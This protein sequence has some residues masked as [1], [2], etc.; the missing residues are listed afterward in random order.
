MKLGEKEPVRFWL[1]RQIQELFFTFLNI[2]VF[3]LLF[4][5]I[6]SFSMDLDE[7]NMA[8]L[9]DWWALVE[10]WAVLRA[11][12]GLIVLLIPFINTEIRSPLGLDFLNQF[13][14][15]YDCTV[16]TSGLFH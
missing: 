11:I 13:I 12:L 10:V 8:Y 4:F 5:D 7:N 16:K 14:W 1:R 15:M 6:F 3:F 2:A 9:G